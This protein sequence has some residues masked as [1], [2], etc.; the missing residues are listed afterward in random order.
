MWEYLLQ[1]LWEG[2]LA[3]GGVSISAHSALITTCSRSLQWP[4][5]LLL[6]HLAGHVLFRPDLIMFNSAISV[7]G[8]AT[9]WSG[10]MELYRQMQHLA[11]RADVVTHGSLASGAP[12]SS[13]WRAAWWSLAEMLRET[14]RP[15]SGARL[16][17][18]PMPGWDPRGTA[19]H[20]WG[21][22]YKKTSAFEV[23]AESRLLGNAGLASEALAWHGFLPGAL[24]AAFRQCAQV[25]VGRRLRRICT[26]PGGSTPRPRGPRLHD[27]LLERH[28][29]FGQ[30]FTYGALQSAGV[31]QQPHLRLPASRVAARRALLGVAAAQG[32]ESLEGGPVARALVARLAYA[33]ATSPRRLTA[34]RGVTSGERARSETTLGSRCGRFSSR[35]AVAPVDPRI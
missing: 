35:A 6:F 13:G 17:P 8:K 4:R 20:C 33:A 30:A 14:L 9:R 31:H 7:C 5:A 27:P 22:A 2:R 32:P 26:T 24:A 16:Y 28:F 1:A 25:P 10:A 12:C 15:S 34:Q 19:T 29:G 3:S 23:Q 18:S 21:T 11:V